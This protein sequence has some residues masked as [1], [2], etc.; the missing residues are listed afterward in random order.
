M[1]VYDVI[2]IGGGQSGM[3]LAYHLRKTDLKYLILDKEKEAGGS[4]QHYW[5]SLRLFSPASFSSLPGTL[6]P[7]GA[8][9]YPNRDE[10]LA[11]LR[12][13]EKKYQ[14]E[15]AHGVEV[16][17]VHY[18]RSI[19]RIL[20]K[21]RTY[22]SKAVVS[23]SGSFS[24]PY[25]PAISHS[26]I[27]EGKILHSANYRSPESF[28]NQKVAVVGEGNSGAQILAEISQY[29][30]TYWLTEREPSFMPD[31]IDGRVLFDQATAMYEAQKKGK[32]FRPPSLGDIVMV[33]SVKDARERGV[34]NA[35]PSIQAFERRGVILKNNE[36]LKVDAVV[37]CTGFRPALDHL[38]PLGVVEANG[39]VLTRQTKAEKQEGLWLVGYGSWTG[40]ASATLIGVGRSA[41]RTA[42]ELK[43]F[44]S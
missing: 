5:K 4:W 36:F 28:A 18:E 15:V 31:D 23:A 11:Y 27:F 32:D 10:T 29:A 44:I 25:I 30:T 34:L 19:F 1:E 2:I 17:E 13:Y 14:L 42:A 16:Q 40:F 38:N 20:T 22:W 41:K 33:P 39:K 21:D 37:F 3:A 7:G 9:Y 43:K 6:M 26:E 35:R 12:Q 24:K 8:D